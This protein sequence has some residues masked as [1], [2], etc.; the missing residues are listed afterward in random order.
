MEQK[1][2]GKREGKVA[3]LLK[4]NYSRKS[5]L[6]KRHFGRGLKEG[7]PLCGHQEIESTKEQ[8][9]WLEWSNKKMRLKRGEKAD[10]TAL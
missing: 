5:S 1:E 3:K 7:R 10:H 9:E 6:R 8:R 2:G 4:I